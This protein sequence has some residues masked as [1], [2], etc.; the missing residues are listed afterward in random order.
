LTA[1]A[2]DVTVSNHDHLHAGTIEA[3]RCPGAPTWH[4]VL[5]AAD[6]VTGDAEA[7]LLAAQMA[8]ATGGMCTSARLVSWPAA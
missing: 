3:S 6:E 7:V 8:S 1:Y 4:R 5:I 2:V